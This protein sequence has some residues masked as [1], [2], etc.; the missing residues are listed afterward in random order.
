MSNLFLIFRAQSRVILSAFVFISF[1]TPS[2]LFAYSFGWTGDWFDR[3]AYNR[4]MSHNSKILKD[5]EKKRNQK[6]N[7]DDKE[8]EESEED[9][10]D[11]ANR[12]DQ[13]YTGGMYLFSGGTLGPYDYGVKELADMYAEKFY[14]VALSHYTNIVPSFDENVKKIYKIP[15]SNIATG[16]AVLLAG[17]YAAYHNKPFPKKF[18]EPTVKQVGELLRAEAKFFTKEDHYKMRIYQITA[19]FG[20]QLQLAQME[21]MKNPDPEV[22]SKM[23]QVGEKILRDILG[24]DPAR[25]DF[26]SQG[27]V[28]R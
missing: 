18:I 19:G 21:M 28:F 1:L 17:G 8:S 3:D 5:A 6:K 13:L 22:I 2:K 7:K 10:E 15:Q 26:T 27:I 23:R 4:T 12:L 11:K 25:V 16:M 14:N 20:L 9:E 24:T